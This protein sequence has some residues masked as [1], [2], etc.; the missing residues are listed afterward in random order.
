MNKKVLM[1]QNLDGTKVAICPE[2]KGIMVWRDLGVS[3]SM[4][5]GGLVEQDYGGFWQCSKC[6]H[7]SD[8]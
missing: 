6:G 8:E 1:V 7:Q 4:Q 5:I 3:M 2:C